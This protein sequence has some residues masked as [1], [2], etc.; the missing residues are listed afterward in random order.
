M[1]KGGAVLQERIWLEG[2]NE[3]ENSRKEESGL[4]QQECHVIF[5]VI[6]RPSLW[7]HCTHYNKTIPVALET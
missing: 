1:D 3:G 2:K 5:P 7:K 4:G 6:P